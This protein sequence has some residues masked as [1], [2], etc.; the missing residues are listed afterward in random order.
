MPYSLNNIERKLVNDVILQNKIK[1]CT[2]DTKKT[3]PTKV[4][5]ELQA[6]C[7][8]DTNIQTKLKWQT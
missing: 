7:R 3:K 6:N 5:C 4:E 2:K 1:S 8:L